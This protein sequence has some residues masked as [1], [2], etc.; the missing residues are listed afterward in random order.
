MKMSQTL[1]AG[2][3]VSFS[4]QTNGI[5]LDEDWAH[6]LRKEAFLVGLSLDGYKDCH[7]ACRVD[8]AGKG[9]WNQVVRTLGMLQK[10][11][12]EVNALCVVTASCARSPDKVYNTLKKLGLRYLQFIAC[13]D[14]LGEARGARP[15]SLTPEAYGKFLCRLFDLWYTD[16]K[17]GDYHSI[18]LFDD[19]VHILL[20]DHASTCS[21][22]GQC[23]SYFV[24]EG[25]G[26][27]YPCDFFVLDQWKM[28]RLGDATLSQMAS[29]EV[30]QRFVTQSA[31]RPDNCSACPWG[32]VCH[33]GC[34]NDWV[35]R[36]GQP[37]NY[38]CTAI[39]ALLDHAMPCLIQIARAEAAAR[40]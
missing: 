32:E 38:N 2:C 19:Y 29:G 10:H 24:A 34:K 35:W 15:Y 5:L 1:P 30:A 28:G 13:L 22:C 21:T 9:S 17:S 7:N 11:Q 37:H 6:F 4:I 26:S 40:R 33:G 31:H 16:W 20:G 8:A 27:I 3:R 23:G 18:R 25:D 14:P 39:R 36:D 12:V